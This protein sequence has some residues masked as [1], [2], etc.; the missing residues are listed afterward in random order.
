MTDTELMR[1]AQDERADLAG[2]L[3]G[4][5]PERWDA[6]TLCSRWRVRDVVAHIISYDDLGPTGLVGRFAKGCGNG[7]CGSCWTRGPS[8]AGSMRRDH[9]PM[10]SAC[11]DASAQVETALDPLATHGAARDGQLSAGLNLTPSCRTWHSR[12]C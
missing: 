6:P 2:F 11:D 8:V 10:F 3:A 5:A 1:L 7:L 4:L 9:R 12:G